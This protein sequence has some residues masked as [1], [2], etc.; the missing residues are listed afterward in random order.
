MNHYITIAAIATITIVMITAVTLDVIA[1]DKAHKGNN[2][3][4]RKFQS[5]LPEELQD[6]PGCHD[7][8]TGKDHNDPPDLP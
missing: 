4:C 6:Y 3:K 1:T 7:T 2:G 8:F 5:Q